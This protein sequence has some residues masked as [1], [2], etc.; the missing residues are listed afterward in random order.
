M[1]A[2]GMSLH[3]LPLFVWAIFVTA[4]L[5]LLS[6][7][8]LAGAITMLLT[9]R[10]FNTSFYDPAGG[11]DPI[12]YQHL[13]LKDNIY[14][15]SIASL[16]LLT[17]SDSNRSF[18]FS[19]FE[20][21]YSKLYPHNPKPSKAFLE[22][23][24]G[25]TEG[26]GSFIVS[27]RGGLQFVITQSSSDV[28]VLNYIQ[29]NFG[30]GKVIQQSKSNNTHRFIVQDVSHILLICLIFNGN[31]PIALFC[32]AALSFDVV[33]TLSI[34]FDIGMNS[35]IL[36]SSILLVAPDAE[37]LS[38]GLSKAEKSR[39]ILSGKLKEI[40][41][42]LMLGNLTCQKQILQKNPTFRFTQG[43]NHKEYLFHLFELFQNYCSKAPK[44]CNILPDKR[45]RKYYT[46]IVFYTCSLPCF[47]PLYEL[48]YVDGKKI[49]PPNI[50]E[51]LTPL[52]LCY[53]ISHAGHFFQKDRAIILSTQGFSPR[54]VELLVKVLTDKFNLKCSINKSGKVFGIRISTK[55]ISIIQSLLKETMPPMMLHK[56]GL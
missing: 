5:L 1:R 20:T 10:N 17:P 45:T 28:Q 27:K 46:Y 51:L 9:D 11:G 4:I 2:P 32:I 38:R 26:D 55:S 8:V 50:G 52:G 19:A 15:L 44:K 36:L 16:P 34:G 35:G 22:W 30:F 25:F 56:I 54:E 41:V 21:M 13:F 31:Y 7:P 37:I 33:H 43:M 39:I 18:D 24:I 40:L 42:G 6:L 12:L 23:F 49:V 47:I 3:K 29:T 53:W 48:F 14:A